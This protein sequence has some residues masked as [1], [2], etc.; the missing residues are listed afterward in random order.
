MVV[1][2]PASTWAMTPRLRSCRGAL[3][4]E[5]E[6]VLV[7]ANLSFLRLHSALRAA[8][9]WLALRQP[10]REGFAWSLASEMCAVAEA[11]A[12]G[13][14]AP[15]VGNRGNQLVVGT[16]GLVRGVK[17]KKPRKGSLPGFY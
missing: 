5:E 13:T 1:V 15:A 14:Q 4:R 10:R 11:R 12:H 3:L 6:E 9:A 17:N 2:L 16:H 8:A 7:M